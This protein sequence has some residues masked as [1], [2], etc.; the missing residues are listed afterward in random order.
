MPGE[1]IKTITVTDQFQVMGQE[2]MSSHKLVSAFSVKQNGK[3]LTE[4]EEAMAEGG[5]LKR[6]LAIHAGK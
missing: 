2:V 3:S 4:N 1:E 5:D 6:D